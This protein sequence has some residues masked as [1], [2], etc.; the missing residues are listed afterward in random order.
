MAIN[1][2]EQLAQHIEFLGLGKMIDD[3]GVGDVSWGFM[4]DLPDECV[5]VFSTDSGVPG[6]R[7]GARIQIIVRGRS[8]R[9]AYERSQEI[10]DALD[11]FEGYLNGDGLHATIEVVNASA[12]LGTDTKR[13]ELYSSNFIVHYCET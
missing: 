4:P 3:D 8:T 7:S 2:I 9:A 5:T 12:G 10:A 13:R 11:D 6:G 1:L